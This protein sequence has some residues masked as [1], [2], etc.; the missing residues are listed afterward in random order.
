MVDA[1]CIP[2]FAAAAGTHVPICAVADADALACCRWCRCSCVLLLLLLLLCRAS[3]TSLL[4]RC[5]H[6]CWN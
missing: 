2:W 1:C 3:T 5:T 4:S 6:A